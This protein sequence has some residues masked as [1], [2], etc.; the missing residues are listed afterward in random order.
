MSGLV[1]LCCWRVCELHNTMMLVWCVQTRTMNAVTPLRCDLIQIQT[2][3]AWLATAAAV[4]GATRLTQVRE[5]H[6]HQ[7]L[8]TVRIPTSLLRMIRPLA[9]LLRLSSLAPWSRARWGSAWRV[10]RALRVCV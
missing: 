4:K 9:A 1:C 3:T 8:A 2:L 10:W 6:N 7:Q 5:E